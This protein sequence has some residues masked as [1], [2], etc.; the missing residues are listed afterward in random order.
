MAYQLVVVDYDFGVGFFI[1]FDVVGYFVVVLV[2][3]EGV[4]FVGW[5]CVG[6]D[7]DVGYVA[8]DGVDE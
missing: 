3:D 4:Y 5:V 7:L 8:F 1:G 6:V 2:G